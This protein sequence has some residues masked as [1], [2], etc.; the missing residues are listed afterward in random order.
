MDTLL[1]PARPTASFITSNTTGTSPAVSTCGRAGAVGGRWPAQP[2]QARSAVL[3]INLDHSTARLAETRRQLEQLGLP[4]HRIPAVDGLALSAPERSRC[5]DPG[6][7]R[8]QFHKS[9]SDGEIGCYLSHLRAW[10]WIVDHDLDYALIL[11]DDVACGPE[12]IAALD[13]LEQ[14]PPGWDLIKLGSFSRK[15]ILA[16][17]S[18]DSFQLCRYLKPPIS[19]FAQVVS[20]RAAEQLLRTRVPFGRPIDVDLQH[21]WETGLE[22]LGLEP[23]PVSFRPDVPSDIDRTKHRHRAASRRFACLWQRA[24]FLGHLWSGH[25]RRHGVGA[26]AAAAFPRRHR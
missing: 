25:L 8:L 11:E 6:L 18:V 1:L 19:A 10:Q 23:Y 9:L 16:T 21:P 26:L 20:R 13:C 5:Y 7:N 14:L 17:T 24:A 22:V 3:V 4:F 2:A 15:P 12:L